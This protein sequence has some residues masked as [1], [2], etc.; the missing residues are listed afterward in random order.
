M[1]SDD[2]RLPSRHLPVRGRN[3]FGGKKD[4][5][6]ASLRPLMNCRGGWECFVVPAESTWQLQDMITLATIQH[7]TT[8]Y[9]SAAQQ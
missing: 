2:L 9:M 5:F 8:Q 7:N 6:F 4:T 3:S 1:E